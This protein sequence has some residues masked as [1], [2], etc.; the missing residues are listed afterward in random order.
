MKSGFEEMNMFFEVTTLVK[1]NLVN[2]ELIKDGSKIKI[3]ESN[4][5]YFIE[6]RMDFILNHQRPYINNLKSSLFKV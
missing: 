5:D 6:K 2:K 1:G 3:T 4:I